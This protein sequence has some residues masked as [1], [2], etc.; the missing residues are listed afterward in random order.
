MGANS[1]RAHGK[2]AKWNDD[3]GFGFV[4]LPQS[5]EE[6]FVHIS[7]FPR[8]GVRP[9]IG[10]SISFEVRTAPDGRK[11]AE[12]VQ[13]AGARASATRTRVPSAEHKRNP[14][15]AVLTIV[16]LD[17]GAV[18]FIKVDGTTIDSSVPVPSGDWIQLPL[19]HE[20]GGVQINTRTA[21]T[22][23]AGERCV[24]GLGVDAL[25]SQSR[26]AREQSRTDAKAM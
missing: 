20:R 18:R 16:M 4:E 13:R 1:M 25:M 5:R 8:D 19:Q 6:I 17:D 7:A 11:R 23:W 26:R 15:K 14:L 3:R 2:L 10:E 12:N 22:R 21:A 24:Y 9:R